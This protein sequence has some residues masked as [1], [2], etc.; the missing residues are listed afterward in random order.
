LKDCYCEGFRTPARQPYPHA[1][2]A[3]VRKAPMDEI[4]RGGATTVRRALRGFDWNPDAYEDGGRSSDAVA[5]LEPASAV[6]NPSLLAQIL[7]K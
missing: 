1:P 2:T 3:G 7:S 5:V 4:A 6:H